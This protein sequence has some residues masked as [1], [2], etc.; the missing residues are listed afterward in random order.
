MVYE[1]E[2][3]KNYSIETLKFLCSYGGNIL[4][5]SNG[6]LRCVGGVTRVLAL[7]R[8]VSYAELMVKLAE[9]CGYSVTLRCQ[10]PNGDLETLI[11]IKSDEDLANLIEEYN[12]ICPN[13]NIR[14][15]LSSRDS[16][17]QISPPPSK[18]Y[19]LSPTKCQPLAPKAVVHIYTRWPPHASNI[20]RKIGN[21]C[22][23]Q[24]YCAPHRYNQSSITANPSV[25]FVVK[26]PFCTY[27]RSIVNIML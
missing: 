19:S 9:F 16:L 25:N 22:F 5:R 26:E 20:H 14:A 2:L 17:K 24:P 21:A 10:L 18:N 11:S 13:S 8:S 15:V 12:K 1:T 23:Y 27:V 4:P 3:E 6:E 7:E